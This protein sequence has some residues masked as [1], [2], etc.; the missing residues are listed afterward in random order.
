MFCSNCGKKIDDNA[1]FCDGC[2]AQQGA[3]NNANSA[4]KQ[5][6]PNFQSNVNYQPSSE[7]QSKKA[8]K[9]KTNIIIT[10]AVV[11]CAFIIG[12]FIIAPSMLSDNGSGNTVSSTSGQNQ[13]DT[14]NNDITYGSS[15][16][17]TNSAYDDILTKAYIVHFQPFFNMD[18]ASFVVEEEN[19]VICCYDF[20]YEGDIVK[21][22][23]E[24]MYVPLSK[25]DDSKKA[26][27]ES[28]FRSQFATLEA[29]DCCEV[30]YK[31]STNYFTVTVTYTA[32][33][34]VENYSALYEV[35]LNDTNNCISM[36]A[37]ENSLLA[38]GAVKKQ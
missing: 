35:G 37:T 10:A 34:K 21:Q 19:G 9:K 20:G 13:T 22:Y 24:T 5:Q 4:S 27:L 15:T 29:L 6:A 25:V 11:L 17:T 28:V 31:M 33:D 16:T 12:K 1:K 32:V 38:K 26:Q 23:V 14:D 7:S 2:G 3:V 36:S 30:D 8:P 18:T